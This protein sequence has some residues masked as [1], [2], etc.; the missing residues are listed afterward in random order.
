[1]LFHTCTQSD[2][3]I[4]LFSFLVFQNKVIKQPLKSLDPQD[5]RLEV[6]TRSPGVGAGVR[7]CRAQ[8]VGHPG[9]TWGK[10]RPRG[11]SC[12]PGAKALS[13]GRGS[14]AEKTRPPSWT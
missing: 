9:R 8:T 4:S 3:L 5:W 13:S 6:P 10:R 2:T 11:G 14:E 7:A 12:C 1:M